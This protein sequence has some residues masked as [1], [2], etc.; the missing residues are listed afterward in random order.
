MIYHIQFFDLHL[1]LFKAVISVQL[2]YFNRFNTN[3]GTCFDFL[4][5]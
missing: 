2:P 1:T 3:I 4:S 5:M